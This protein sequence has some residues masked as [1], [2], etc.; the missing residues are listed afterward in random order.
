MTTHFV[1]HLFCLYLFQNYK[2]LA[3]YYSQQNI[4]IQ[5]T[6][7]CAQEGF[8]EWEKTYFRKNSSSSQQEFVKKVTIPFCIKLPAVKPSKYSMDVRR[9]RLWLVSVG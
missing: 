2:H 5:K 8:S 6:F 7:F 9:G 4:L 1:L 3:L